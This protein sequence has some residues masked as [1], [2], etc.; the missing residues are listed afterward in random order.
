MENV[1]INHTDYKEIITFVKQTFKCSA[2]DFDHTKRVKSIALEIA[3]DF[4]VNMEVLIP[5]IYLHDIARALSDE[6]NN[7]KICHANS[8]SIISREFLLENNYE[9]GIIDQI[10][11]CIESHNYKG[12]IEPKTIEAKV[13][14][15]ADKIDGLGATGIARL[16]AMSGK[17]GDCIF[18]SED[19]SIIDSSKFVAPNIEFKQKQLNIVDKLYLNKSREIGIKRIKFMRLFFNTLEYEINEFNVR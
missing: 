1:N 8:G 9:E 7:R 2:H 10:C 13:L 11:H 6:E 16:F 17:Y 14:F 4:D 12:G 18:E 3:K 15:D 5:A 19:K